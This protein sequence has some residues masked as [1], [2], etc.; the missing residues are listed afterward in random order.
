[1]S[2][3]VA[4]DFVDHELDGLYS[5]LGRPSIALERLLRAQLLMVLYS[6]RS[7]GQL[8]EQLNY[9][10]LYRWLVGLEMDDPVWDQTVFV[11]LTAGRQTRARRPCALHLLIA[12]GRSPKSCAFAV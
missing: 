4:G 6:I 2:G 8:M 1:M 9:N 10:L 12:G 11:G 3:L 5:E 7:E